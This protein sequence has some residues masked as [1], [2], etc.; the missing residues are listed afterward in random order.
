MCAGKPVDVA[1]V[2]FGARTG[3]VGIGF[4]M[5][6]LMNLRLT[7]GSG[8]WWWVSSP[9]S[10]SRGMV[11]ISPGIRSMVQMLGEVGGRRMEGD[12]E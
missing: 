11:K 9:E 8:R 12:K 7:L 3:E 6:S 10:L 2:T 5:M 1:F 4:S